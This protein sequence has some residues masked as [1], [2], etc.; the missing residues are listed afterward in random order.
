MPIYPPDHHL[1][2]L[3]ST[4]ALWRR[5]PPSK[6]PQL[7]QL[8]TR[9]PQGTHRVLN[10]TLPKQRPCRGQPVSPLQESK[11]VALPSRAPHLSRHQAGGQ[12]GTVEMAR[13]TPSGT[14]RSLQGRGSP[15]SSDEITCHSGV[16]CSNMANFQPKDVSQ[17]AMCNPKRGC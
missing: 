12:A 5:F 2:A 9:L 14:P 3:L 16:T 11:C 1:V 10:P 13:R 4:P 7:P 17:I 8:P 15:F 6:W